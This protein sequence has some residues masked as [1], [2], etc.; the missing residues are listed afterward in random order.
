[1]NI[2]HLDPEAGT[3]KKPLIEPPSPA[4][5]TRL[6]PTVRIHQAVVPTERLKTVTPET[7]VNA[8]IAFLENKNSL[9]ELTVVFEC[10]ALYLRPGDKIYVRQNLYNAAWASQVYHL[11]GKDFILVPVDVVVASKKF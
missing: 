3:F 6:P 11:E 9:D 2:R 10:E 1:M 8:G 4:E 7:K 5:P